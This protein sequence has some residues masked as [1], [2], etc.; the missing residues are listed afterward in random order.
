MVKKIVSISILLIAFLFCSHSNAGEKKILVALIDFAD[1]T[2]NKMAITPGERTERSNVYLSEVMQI[3]RELTEKSGMFELL[4]HKTVREA[5]NTV[6]GKEAAARRYDR[7]SS[8]RFGKMLGV[9]AIFTGEIVQFE[10][11]TIPRDLTI[12]GLD[13]S[14]REKD[15]I[16]RARLINAYNGTELADISGAGTADEN[17]LE[18]VSAAV[19]NKLSIGFLQATKISVMKILKELSSADI[20]IDKEY[21]PAPT[22][23]LDMINYTVT[24]TE[25]KYIYINAGLNRSVCVTDLFT[26][27]KRDDS[28]NLKPSAVYSVSTVDLNSS[29]L[30]LL[31]PNEALGTVLVGDKAQRKTR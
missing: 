26:I 23:I 14:K 9:D 8:A 19:V 6:I 21:V 12:N 15:V 4:P 18:T 27:L 7:F 3:I 2:P 16:I 24:K 31:E 10:K 22:N 5:M 13:F 11:N 20:K 28:G 17:V 25:G 1:E 29:K 30:V